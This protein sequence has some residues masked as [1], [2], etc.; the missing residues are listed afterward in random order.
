[1]SRTP[2][3]PQTPVWETM[4]QMISQEFLHFYIL[5]DKDFFFFLGFAGGM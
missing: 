3:G 2:E 1:M 5:C 4:T